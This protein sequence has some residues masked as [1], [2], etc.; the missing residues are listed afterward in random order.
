MYFELF[1]PKRYDPMDFLDNLYED[2][3][4]LY[5]VC[6]YLR[7]QHFVIELVSFLSVAKIVLIPSF[8]WELLLT[9]SKQNKSG[10]DGIV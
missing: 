1:D 7:G 6:V 3:V 9:E 8:G 2:T 5:V 4:C 10:G